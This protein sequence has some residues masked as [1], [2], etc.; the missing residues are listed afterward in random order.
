MPFLGEMRVQYLWAVASLWLRIKRP[1]RAAHAY[2]R[3]LR[4]RPD[5]RHVIFQR[6]WCLIDVPHRRNEAIEAL[7]QLLEESPY[8]FGFFLLG[9]AVQMEGRHQEAVHA[10]EKAER[11]SSPGP[12]ELY[13][14]WGK[15][16]IALRR[17]EEAADA[18][19]HAAL[20]NPSDVVAWR[21]LGGLFIELGRW[22]DGTACQERVMRLQPSVTH[23]LE[24]A[25]TLYE[26]NRPAEA[27]R[28]LREVL[29]LDPQS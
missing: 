12:A 10:F 25:A 8:A 4:I 7:R 3:I 16:L 24:L 5:D 18:F 13:F 21:I 11:T 28:V 17:R 9:N 29:A 23:G 6:A 15:S 27:E 20:L 2:A 22:T 26:L 1:E 14:N 19:R